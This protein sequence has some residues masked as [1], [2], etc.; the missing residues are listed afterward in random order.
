[1]GATVSSCTTKSA[2]ADDEQSG[3]VVASTPAQERRGS[4]RMSKSSRIDPEASG[5]P[6]F[7]PD[8]GLTSNDIE[9]MNGLVSQAATV[10]C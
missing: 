5:S 4:R 1:M 6:I 9:F 2:A 3:L 10:L 8:E 7:K